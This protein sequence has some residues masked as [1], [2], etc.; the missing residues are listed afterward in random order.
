MRLGNRAER[1]Q[2]TAARVG[3]DHIDMAVAL[4]HRL[5]QAVDICKLAH[6]AAHAGDVVT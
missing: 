2:L 1:C 4:L 6:I 5:I 3:K